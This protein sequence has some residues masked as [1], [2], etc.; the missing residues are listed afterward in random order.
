MAC[1][2]GKMCADYTV[3]SACS[4]PGCYNSGY[5]SPELHFHAFPAH[6]TRRSQW[7]AATKRDSGPAFQIKKGSTYVCSAHFK[8]ED[9]KWTPVRKSLKADAVPR[10]FI[11]CAGWE[12]LHSG[13]QTSDTKPIPSMADCATQ[14]LLSVPWLSPDVKQEPPETPPLLLLKEE[15]PEETPVS[16]V[17]TEFE[18][19]DDGGPGEAVH[20]QQDE[21]SD[22]GDP[23]PGVSD[24]AVKPQP[25]RCSDCVLSFGTAFQLTEHRRLHTGERPYKCVQCGKM[26]CHLANYQQHLER[27]DQEPKS[28]SPRLCPAC[29]DT[30]PPHHSLE[31]HLA[32]HCQPHKCAGCKSGFSTLEGYQK[33]L[34]RYGDHRRHKCPDCGRGFKKRTYMVKHQLRCPKREPP[35]GEVPRRAAGRGS[36]LPRKE[37]P[38]CP[39]C[40]RSFSS[41]GV[42]RRHRCNPFKIHCYACGSYFGCYRQYESH[43]RGGE[44]GGCPGNSEEVLRRNACP[45][46]GSASH[47]FQGADPRLWAV[48][49]GLA[50]CRLCRKGF[51]FPCQLEPH[52]RMHESK[53]GEEEDGPQGI[54]AERERKGADSEGEEDGVSSEGWRASLEA[55]VL[56]GGEENGVDSEGE[57]W[58]ASLEAAVLEGGEENGVDA[59]GE[60]W[61]ASLEAA[62][63]EGG[64]E[65]GVD[66]EGEGQREGG[67]EEEEEGLLKCFDCGQLFGDAEILHEHYMQHARGEL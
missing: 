22:A 15:P 56:E 63:L 61:R 5:R 43:K 23:S 57:E 27:H 35:G 8:P 40:N 36:P 48:A 53:Q 47:T 20:T 44:A 31:H 65:N 28:P 17:K 52:H 66:S 67:L 2:D 41:P 58:R 64:E 19:G 49:G 3:H 25:H 9:Y 39:G 14:Q 51:R 6:P 10:I 26:F 60:E 50:T 62:V 38:R 16:S 30:L 29:G 18:D 13:Q 1:P 4:V 59:E 11:H 37:P 34:R 21:R 55:A 54:G 42:F 12:D 32:T 45:R 46:C 33:H 7:I 24:S